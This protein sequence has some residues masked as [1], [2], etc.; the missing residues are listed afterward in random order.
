M[1]QTCMFPSRRRKPGL[2][3]TKQEGVETILS[4]ANELVRRIGEAPYTT[5]RGQPSVPAD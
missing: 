5:P 2:G 1:S 4:R 3:V